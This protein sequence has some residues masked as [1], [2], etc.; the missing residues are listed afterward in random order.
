MGAVWHEGDS[1]TQMLLSPSSQPGPPAP[2]AGPGARGRHRLGPQVWRRPCCRRPCYR[3]PCYWR[4][5]C[6]R[7]WARPWAQPKPAEPGGA[8]RTDSSPATF[9][10][11][12]QWSPG[13]GS[14]VAVTIMA[15]LGGCRPAPTRRLLPGQSVGCLQLLARPEVGNPTLATPWQFPSNLRGTFLEQGKQ[16]GHVIQ[17]LLKNLC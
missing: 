2:P 4:P 12:L 8:V 1:V 3:Q 11:C 16:E 14:V 7:P 6:R 15:L 13:V 17:G 5:C 10:H 9:P